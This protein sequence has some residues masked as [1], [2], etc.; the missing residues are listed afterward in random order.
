MRRLWL[1]LLLP[2]AVVGSPPSSQAQLP[3]YTDDTEVTGRGTLHFEFSNE[4]DA[5][6]SSEY[7]DLRQNTANFKVNYGLPH[8]LELDFDA[9]H[10]SIYRARTTPSAS[11]IGDADL[12]VKWKFRASAPGSHAPALA[13]SLYVEFLTGDARQQLSS[14]KRDYWLNFIVQVPLSDKTRLNLN[15]GFLFAGNT[16]TGAVGIQ[17][18]RGQVFTGGVCLLHDFTSRL[19][20]GDELYGGV[21]DNDLLGRGQLQGLVGGECSLGRGFAFTFGVLAGKYSASPRIGL[22]IGLVLD[23]PGIFR[24]AHN[25]PSYN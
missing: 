20:L 9:P 23:V 14:G 12:G 8:G 17:T 18:T 6:H 5:L 22:Q 19:T 16:S 10:L 15:S 7:P 2:L 21:A 1:V 13:A 24:G 25:A 11:G 4:Y 3:F